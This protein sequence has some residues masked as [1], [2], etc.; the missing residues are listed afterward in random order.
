MGTPGAGD[1]T[2]GDALL[3]TPPTPGDL[4]DS[5]VDFERAK[6]S[7]LLGVVEEALRNFTHVHTKA[8]VEAAWATPRRLGPEC[9]VPQD[10][11]PALAVSHP[12]HPLNAL[13]RALGWRGV[14]TDVEWPRDWAAHVCAPVPVTLPAGVVRADAAA[15]GVRSGGSACVCPG[16]ARCGH[17]TSG[18]DGGVGGGGVTGTGAK[19]SGLG[20]GVGTPAL[21][22]GWCVPHH[23]PPYTV[24]DDVGG[25]LAVVESP[26]GSPL[27][28]CCPVEALCTGLD[29]ARAATVLAFGERVCSGIGV[30]GTLQC[31]PGT[32]AHLAPLRCWLPSP[33]VEASRGT[34]PT[35]PQGPGQDLCRGTL[36]GLCALDPTLLLVDVAADGHLA[37]VPVERVRAL[38]A[39]P[40]QFER[41]G[42]VAPKSVIDDF[43]GVVRDRGWRSG[44]VI[45]PPRRV[46]V[47]AH[48]GWVVGWDC[49]GH[50]FIIALRLYADDGVGT[51]GSL[52]A[53]VCR[54]GTAGGGVGDCD[55]G[56]V[57]LPP[58]YVVVPPAVLAAHNPGVTQEQLRDLEAWL[59]DPWALTGS[60]TL[61]QRT[62]QVQS[63]L[64]AAPRS[65]QN[66]D[67]RFERLACHAQQSD[68]SR[69]SF[70]VE[71]AGEV[72]LLL[73]SGMAAG[74]LLVSDHTS[75][76]I[77]ACHP[78]L[79]ACRRVR[80]QLAGGPSVC[81]PSPTV[82][83][84]LHVS[85][86]PPPQ[87]SPHQPPS[88]PQP[89]SPPR[90]GA[91]S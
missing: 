83:S 51:P 49:T 70:H 88:P 5:L 12:A 72:C 8:A 57:A 74:H 86:L 47:D 56:P 22:V 10:G 18:S 15:D 48:P 63:W 31:A 61:R 27:L 46:V 50:G 11:L 77:S 4:C 64:L 66:R 24:G 1:P 41:A 25:M 20:C 42:D 89:H 37:R 79:T 52:L 17:G 90:H 33:G 87:P 91:C 81:A 59:T 19:G 6:A 39:D 21:L 82:W 34:G 23:L 69:W 62:V 29:P 9:G 71:Q 40:R 76:D 14:P 45:L 7:R 68:R 55:G 16:D 73:A 75:W 2:R 60:T 13:H 28:S 30:Q 85:F 38:C 32:T 54:H 43:V 35:V 84:F 58:G 67:A 26:P 44:S 80:H 3:G 78:V 65:V 53:H 36:A